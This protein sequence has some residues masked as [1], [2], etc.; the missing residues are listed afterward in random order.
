MLPPELVRARRK[1]E[2]LELQKF[3]AAERKRALEL[4]T[5][6][7]ALLESAVG[8]TQDEVQELL[9]A[10]DHEAREAKLVAGL[11]KLAL[12][13]ADFGAPLDWDP[14]EFRRA[15]F[16]R[17]SLVRS[18]LEPSGRFPRAEVIEQAAAELGI[19]RELAE[20]ALFG[21]LK[22]AAKL[23]KAP[24][25]GPEELVERFEWGQLQGV[26]ARAVRLRVLLRASSPD[27]LRVF[28]HKLK[29]RQLLHTI[30]REGDA[31]RVD[32]DGPFSVLE[33]T[34]R[35]G[36]ALSLLVPALREVGE[37]EISAEIRWGK[38]R[39]PL[40]FQHVL[41]TTA[42]PREQQP[43]RSELA[44]LLENGLGDP[45]ITVRPAEQLLDVPG[46][47]LIVPDL[48]F[49]A[50]GKPRVHLELLGYWRREAVWSRVSWAEG[51]K[52]E[53]VVF[54]VSSRLRVSESVLD[55]ES[56]CSLYVFKGTLGRAAL[57]ERVRKLMER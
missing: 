26:L 45:T 33:A 44:P 24:V 21:D 39:R 5:D 56:A 18:E 9:A 1:G 19:A 50:P 29:F 27:A 41:R 52:N 49:E 31:Y 8:G 40:T 53:R 20:D 4:S 48:V 43:A 13:E 37:C 12:D 28:F 34:T 17:A 46:L 42:A 15:V 57:L 22:G 23:V 7:L 51:Q 3:P 30:T 32:I 14:R 38:E 6:I 16:T 11:R 2:T 54:A 36:L 35:Y 10:V 55:D 25:F 47:G